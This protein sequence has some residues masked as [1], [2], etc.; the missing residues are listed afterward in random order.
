LPEK[1]AELPVTECQPALQLSMRLQQ[2][3]TELAIR[4]TT[5]SR[6]SGPVEDHSEWAT[7][8]EDAT[9]SGYDASNGRNGTPPLRD[10]GTGRHRGTRRNRSTRG[11]PRNRSSNAN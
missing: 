7:F 2:Q 3:M 5:R 9:T 6:H 4:A 11:P 1:L 10:H 8:D